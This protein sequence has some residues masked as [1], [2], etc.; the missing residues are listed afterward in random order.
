MFSYINLPF[1]FLSSS[2]SA[3]QQPSF[4]YTKLRIK[5]IHF[6]SF[7]IHFFSL[8]K[9]LKSHFKLKGL[10]NKWNNYSWGKLFSLI[11]MK[12][13]GTK[14]RNGLGFTYI[15]VADITP[16]C[17]IH[18]HWKPCKQ[19]LFNFCESNYYWDHVWCESQ[20][21]NPFSHYAKIE[22]GNEN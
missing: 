3:R 4:F 5:W 21:T 22:V 2:F 8:I 17:Q 13:Q 19:P 18:M 7:I 15:F 12:R 16:F 9:L 1:L 10:P 20:N 6:C 14:W 11:T